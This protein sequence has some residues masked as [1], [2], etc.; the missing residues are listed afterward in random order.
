[1]RL[2]LSQL[3]V[4]ETKEGPLR[5]AIH[6]KKGHPSKCSHGTQIKD[7]EKHKESIMNLETPC[8]ETLSNTPCEFQGEDH[9]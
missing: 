8:K 5:V 9:C 3:Q 2:Q 1:V 7:E 6:S 4:E